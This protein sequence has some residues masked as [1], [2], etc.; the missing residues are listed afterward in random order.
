[1]GHPGA[2][3]GAHP[4][5]VVPMA[6][7]F[8]LPAASLRVFQKAVACIAKLG[9]DATV[10]IK[11]EELVLH[12]EDDAHSAAL[13]FGF[14][15]KFF[16]A[17]PLTQQAAA[18][19]P[20]ASSRIVV[21]SRS[22]LLALKGAQQRSTDCLLL[23]L[24]GAAEGEPRLVLDFAARFGGKVR[25]RV[26]LLDVD[27]VLPGE[28]KAGPHVAALR[29]ALLSKVLDYSTAP[30]AR[31]SACEEVTLSARP[32]E[33]LLI[34]SQDLVSAGAAAAGTTNRT[35]VL[36][37]QTDLAVHSW[38][39]DG[40]ESTFSGRCLKEFA[41]AAETC[42]RDLV[43]MGLM[44]GDP[45]LEIRFGNA[46]GGGSIV[47]R[48]VMAT[49]TSIAP[50]RDFSAVL[51]VCTRDFHAANGA[52]AQLSAAPAAEPR[53]TASSNG[54][55]P[56]TTAGGRRVQRQGSKRRVVEE[57]P[58]AMAFDAF[59]GSQASQPFP[60]AMMPAPAPGLAASQSASMHSMPPFS[61]SAPSGL[62]A[63]PLPVQQI[64]QPLRPFGSSQ[65]PPLSQRPSQLPAIP[66]YVPLSAPQVSVHSTA[67]SQMSV[68]ATAMATR[69][70]VPM[71]PVAAMVAQA[72]TA[73][74]A[75]VTQIA[76]Q[77]AMPPAVP[78]FAPPGVA[79]PI[80]PVAHVAAATGP[81]W[82]S[83]QA[84]NTAP[85]RVV[86]T[87][88]PPT[89]ASKL[90]NLGAPVDE[91]DDDE[92]VGADPDELAFSGFADAQP[93]PNEDVTDWFDH[94]KLW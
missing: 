9:R 84:F 35:E 63:P 77:A 38:T 33:G 46:D 62:S 70:P 32:H 79:A 57:I 56:A 26:P 87:G 36:V 27:P 14:Q 45:L 54:T 22:L 23:S 20:A 82:S 89:L 19:T 43:S 50:L 17:T 6:T 81:W 61:A 64:G 76:Q 51:M 73:R 25:H 93:C 5:G 11:P 8:E 10:I 4:A 83:G 12:G 29:S 16:R 47:C 58:A 90:P 85:P 65:E 68:P 28:P 40:G 34:R 60:A 39:A 72:Q 18:R 44:D 49:E 80:A 91:S 78:P 30:G 7:S 55:S 42:G 24:S 13:Q 15:K 48:M 67:S 71:A 86:Q 92:L 52:G 37:Q 53:G 31:G 2:T 74:V 66:G 94:D 69:P 41:K 75:P 59:P 88:P 3:L 1:M 21:A